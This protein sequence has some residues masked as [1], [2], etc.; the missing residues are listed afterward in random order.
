MITRHLLFIGLLFMSMNSCASNDGRVTLKNVDSFEQEMRADLPIAT[1]KARIESYLT[2]K[3]IR[4][5]YSET[6][7]AIYAG[8][9]KI[10]KRML[11]YEASLAIEIQLDDSKGLQVLNFRVIYDGL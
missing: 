10:G 2:A 1:P 5:Q 8:I 9:P 4:Y 6:D 11:I 3:G 7:N